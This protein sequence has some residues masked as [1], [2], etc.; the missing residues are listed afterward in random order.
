MDTSKDASKKAY[1]IKYNLENY[2]RLTEYRAEYRKREGYQAKMVAYHAEYKKQ[3]ITAGRY[4]C[5]PCVHSFQTKNDLA[6]HEKSN[7]HA[8]KVSE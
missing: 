2:E 6:R 5:A 1:H 3:N 8:K 7:K 4:H